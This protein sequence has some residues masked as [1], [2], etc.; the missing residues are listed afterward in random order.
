[1]DFSWQKAFAHL[2]PDI[3]ILF[4]MAFDIYPGEYH[5]DYP[6]ANEKHFISKPRGLFQLKELLIQTI[7]ISKERT[8]AG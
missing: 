6:S 2:G 1:M 4:M 7:E 8:K 3:P 5:A